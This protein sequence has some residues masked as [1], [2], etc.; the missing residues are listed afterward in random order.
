MMYIVALDIKGT[1]M[2]VHLSRAAHIRFLKTNKALTI[3]RIEY[4]DYTDVFSLEL[5]AELP[6]HTG[7]NHH[8]IEPEEDKQ[9]TYSPIYSLEP[10]ELETFKAYIKTNLVNSF[11]R[12]S[13][14]LV[15]A[16]IFFNHK[17]NRSFCL[18]IN[19]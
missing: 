16:P 5:T 9:P 14:S 10:I 18:C 3:V 4:F 19:L 12:P 7:I 6:K 15:G 17:P 13:K 8:I 11:I 2:V 1:Y